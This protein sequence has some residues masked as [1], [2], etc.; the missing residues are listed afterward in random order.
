M[1]GGGKKGGIRGRKSLKEEGRG[2]N[3][4]GLG[5]RVRKGKKEGQI[6]G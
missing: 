6:R 1:F 3:E 2:Q 4:A 5:E